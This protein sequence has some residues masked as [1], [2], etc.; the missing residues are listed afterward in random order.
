LGDK[1]AWRLYHRRDLSLAGKVAERPD[2]TKQL[3][4]VIDGTCERLH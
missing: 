4:L 2:L 1:T 3:H